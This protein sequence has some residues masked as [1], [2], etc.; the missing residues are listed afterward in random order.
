MTQVFGFSTIA[1]ASRAASSGRQRNATSAAFNRAARS[2][3]I[4]PLGRIDAEHV[5]VVPA[6]QH[7]PDA[8]PGR[9][10]LSVHVHSRHLARLP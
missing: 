4:L 7:L 8:Q 2:A 10:L 5:D 9:A 3:G 1:T 6:R